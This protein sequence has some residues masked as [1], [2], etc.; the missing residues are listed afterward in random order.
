MPY[1]VMAEC[2]YSFKSLNDIINDENETLIK[3]LNGEE[4]E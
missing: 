1:N 2:K 3:I 4:N